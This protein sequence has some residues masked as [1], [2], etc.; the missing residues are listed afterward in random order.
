MRF[1]KRVAIPGSERKPLFDAHQVSEVEAGERVQVSVFLRR[2]GESPS[3]GK[4]GQIRHRVTHREFAEQFGA[5]PSDI[6]LVEGFAHHSGLTVVE[7]SVAKHRV[8]LAGTVDAVA[9]AFGA[10]VA[11]F[12]VNT[13]GPTYRGRT[14]ELTVPGELNKVVVA[15][16]GLDTR[17]AANPHFRKR[18]PHAVSTTFTPPQVAALYNFPSGLTGAGETIAIIELGGGYSTSDLQTYF[19][20]LGISEP[21]ITAVS[22]DGGTNSPGS[23][24]DGEVMLD[25]EVAGSVA[26]GANIAVYFA[27]N[28]DQGFIDAITDAVHDSARKPS[29]VSISWGGPEDSW[30]PQSQT[31]MNAALEDAAA[32]GVTVLSRQETTALAMVQPTASCTSTSPPRAP[33][34]LPA[35][36]PR[37]PALDPPYLPKSSGTKLPIRKA[38][39]EAV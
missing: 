4:H 8:V 39:Q 29:V 12:K 35:E 18:K 37:S 11:C 7:S 2:R 38:Q 30:T 27:P 34:H 19:Q 15:V 22:V 28:T 31:A 17:R 16:L 23:D 3:G 20:E 33:T 36:E 21:S 24:A 1:G 13:T 9:K 5:D 25:I 26:P 32:L 14:G 6:A 10:T